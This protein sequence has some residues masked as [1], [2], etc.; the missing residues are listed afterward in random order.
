MFINCL[1]NWTEHAYIQPTTM[2]KYCELV[3]I[4]EWIAYKHVSTYTDE[5]KQNIT[6]LYIWYIRITVSEQ[7]TLSENNLMHVW[8]F[9]RVHFCEKFW[10][11]YMDWMRIIESFNEY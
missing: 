10:E 8:G 1:L 11:L 5:L 6:W 9:V 4:K 2:F 3:K 7:V